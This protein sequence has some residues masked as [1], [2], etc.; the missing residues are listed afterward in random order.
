M[1]PSFAPL[2]GDRLATGASIEDGLRSLREAGA[3]PID[4]IM[5]IRDV[6]KTD[7]AVAKQV[8]VDSAVW[9]DAAEAAQILHEELI[10]AI[11]AEQKEVADPDRQRA[12]RD[13][14]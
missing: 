2:L 12:T 7:L 11:E 10:A 4:A 1:R 3:S 6:K 5:A 8:F 14:T 13:M 9:R